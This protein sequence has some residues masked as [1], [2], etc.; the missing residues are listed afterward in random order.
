MV[1][2][3]RFTTLLLAYA[4]GVHAPPVLAQGNNTAAAEAFFQEGRALLDAGRFA[5]A[6]PKLAQSHRLDPATGTL[7]ALAMCHEGEGKLATAWAEFTEVEGRAQREDRDDR[8]RLAQERA[9]ALKPRLSS[10]AVEV[11][12]DVAATPGLEVR[13]NG[14]IVDAALFGAAAPMDGGE[15]LV[16]AVAPGKV[17]WR[18]VVTVKIESDTVRVR[19]PALKTAAT[20]PEPEIGST[21]PATRDEPTRQ[22]KGGS[23]MSTTGLVAA[24]VGLV[25]IGVGAYLIL[26]AKADY[27][28]A[29]KL[30]TG[31]DKRTC[32]PVPY[33]SIQDAR[34]QGPAASVVSSIGGAMLV[35]G[36]TL[37]FLAPSED[38]ESAP[39][40]DLP[41]VE[42]VGV[43]PTSLVVR[44]TF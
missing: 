23:W 18:S 40:G 19:V 31:P 5:E 4:V 42:G 44:G 32:K 29:R 41:R 39:R 17:P 2:M 43:G 15:H 8:V 3:R 11:P 28:D 16:E 22:E 10:L 26:D 25:G 36:A 7:L 1:S 38:D 13:L 33:Q 34:G 37:F 6:C 12:P 27:E 9:A 14:T 20:L 21:G 30:C 24:G 35:G